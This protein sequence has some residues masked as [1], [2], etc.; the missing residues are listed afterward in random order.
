[1]SRDFEEAER[2]YEDAV[3][4]RYN[5]DYHQSAIHRYH[6]DQ[7][8]DWV[9][10]VAREN[11]RVVDLGCGPASLWH[12]WKQKLPTP[13]S[14]TGI[15]FSEGMVAECRRLHPEDDFRVGSALEIPLE[16]GT[17]DLLIISSVLHHIPDEHLEAAFAECSRVLDE[18]GV[19]VGR[20][21]VGV[22]RLGDEPGWFSGAVM[23]FRH[24]VYRLTRTIAYPEPD[25]GP[26]HHAYVPRVF[27][28]ALEKLFRPSGFEFRFPVSSYVA[29]CDD[30]RVLRLVRFLEERIGHMGGQEFFYQAHKNYS[31][32][33]EV[34][35]CALQ[36]I[37]ENEC[38]EIDKAEF[39][40]L[41]QCA[42][43]ILERELED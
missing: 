23:A 19:L 14:L 41:L 3:A 11:L 7:F 27:A 10:E 26:H 20:E 9:A 40:A 1:M 17:V 22:H 16:D 25:V 8:T 31:D 13:R 12:Y 33:A 21:P 36:A 15:D 37:E 5:D 39:L 24:M 32:V 4:G 43:E 18:H 30:G 35:H 2:R 29:N 34:A 28:D 38:G 42:S 6:D